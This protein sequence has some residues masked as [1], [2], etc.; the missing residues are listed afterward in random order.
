MWRPSCLVSASFRVQIRC[1]CLSVPPFYARAY[2]AN[3]FFASGERKCD[4]DDAVPE[5]LKREDERREVV[6]RE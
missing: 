3:Q 2:F 6:Q 1:I 4:V 5:P